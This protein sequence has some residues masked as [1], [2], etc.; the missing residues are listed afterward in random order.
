MTVLTVS[1]FFKA[2]KFDLGYK[3]FTDRLG[4][5]TSTV[6]AHSEHTL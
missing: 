5:V 6:W 1:R 4:K 3:S 2:K